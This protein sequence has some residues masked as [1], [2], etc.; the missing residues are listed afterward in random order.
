MAPTL[1][2]ITG[3]KDLVNRL[4]ERIRKIEQSIT[5]DGGES[6]SGS[7]ELRMILMG[8]PGAGSFTFFHFFPLPLSAVVPLAYLPTAICEIWP[9]IREGTT[10][11]NI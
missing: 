8:P 7:G 5:G 10:S 3:L 2:D 11:A 4:Q 1:E 6:K 9:L